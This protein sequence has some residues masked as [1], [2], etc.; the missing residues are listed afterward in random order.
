MPD[1]RVCATSQVEPGNVEGFELSTP[2]GSPLS[3]AVIH[4][5]S[6]R[7][8]ASQNRCSHGRFKLSEGWVEDDT[9]EC[10]RHGAAFD[11]ATGNVITPPATQPITT[12]P[13]TLDGTDVYITI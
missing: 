9:I 4:T 10:T 2:D 13:V 7:W 3:V 1:I 11:L 5:E 12:Y 6:G 8:F